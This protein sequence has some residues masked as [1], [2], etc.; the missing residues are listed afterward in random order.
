M[1]DAGREDPHAVGPLLPHCFTGDVTGHGPPGA[2]SGSDRP[3]SRSCFTTL[4]T[5]SSGARPSRRRSFGYALAADGRR[6]TSRS[7][8]VKPSN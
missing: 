3:P 8:T 4:V 1:N 7:D 5:E 2:H 6:D